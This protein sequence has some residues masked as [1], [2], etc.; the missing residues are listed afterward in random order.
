MRNESA[1]VPSSIG[2]SHESLNAAVTRSLREAIVKGKFRP[3]ERLREPALARMFQVSRNPVREA[4]LALKAEG[5]IETSPRRGARVRL[6]SET[7]AAEII[8][9]RVELERINARHAAQRCDDELRRALSELVEAGNEAA[10]TPN[11]DLLRELNDRFHD[12]VA[13]GGRNRYVADYVRTLRE[14][15][16]W[17]FAS[18]R[19]E[20]VVESWHEHAA[21]AKSILAGDAEL[22]GLLAARHVQGAGEMVRAELGNEQVSGLDDLAP[23]P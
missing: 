17:L 19:T 12:I 16:L 10:Q 3:G 9:L 23:V 7:D 6:V 22:A 11:T 18:A 2:T 21:I 13:D 5:L 4:L 8:E 20:R 1:E 14:K 15:T